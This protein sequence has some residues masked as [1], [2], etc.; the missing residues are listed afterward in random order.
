MAAKGG[1][2]IVVDLDQVPQREAGMTPYEI[3][4]S[5]SQERMLLV[6][7]PGNVPAVQDVFAKWDLD[8]PVIGEVAE[9]GRARISFK[10]EV[11]VDIP[12]DAVVNLCP[13]YDRPITPPS[14][15]PAAP[16]LGALPLPEDLGDVLLRLLASP[17]IADKEWVFRQ[18]D[19]M[20]QL[21]TVFLPGADAAVL[22]IK[23]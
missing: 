4:L 14:P 5:E 22:R 18:Y 13:A 17:T 8:A 12:V 10:G 6:A 9:G 21:N 20:V 1:M 3:L 23:G 15:P 7:T 19:H 11:V 16:P 2:G